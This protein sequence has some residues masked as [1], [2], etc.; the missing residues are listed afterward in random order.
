MQ[1]EGF[2]NFDYDGFVGL[3]APAKTSQ[4]IVAYLNKQL[5]DVVQSK[6]FAAAWKRSA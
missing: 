3:A 2:P 1:E 4:P 6:E 5:N